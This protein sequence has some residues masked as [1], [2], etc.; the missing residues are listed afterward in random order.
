MSDLITLPLP[1]TSNH[2][3]AIRVLKGKSIMFKTGEAR[4]WEEEAGYLLKRAWKRKPIAVPCYV[5]L[6]FFLKFDRDIDAGKLLLDALQ[7]AG[8][9]FNDK[10]IAHLNIRK[11]KDKD[12]PHVE[13]EVRELG[14]DGA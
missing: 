4:A 6:T 13:V 10:L 11:I 14:G 3:Y 12:N 2:A 9:L 1:P 8:V 7:T 5:G